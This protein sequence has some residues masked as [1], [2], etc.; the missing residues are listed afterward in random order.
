MWIMNSWICKLYIEF[1]FLTK[2]D[3]I[4]LQV[5]HLPGHEQHNCRCTQKRAGEAKKC[6]LPW[7][8][9]SLQFTLVLAFEQFW[10]FRLFCLRPRMT[11]EWAKNSNFSTSATHS[12][13]L[14]PWKWVKCAQMSKQKERKQICEIF[15]ARKF[16]NWCICHFLFSFAS[17][18]SSL[19]GQ[20]ASF[21]HGFL[22]FQMRPALSACYHWRLA[23]PIPPPGFFAPGP[24]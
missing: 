20:R 5:E 3:N 11:D 21:S 16:D 4:Y 15:D 10:V 6:H 17:L 24:D 22:L 2:V 18:S 23:R 7:P 19:L 9:N 14:L 8:T 13:Q 1:V 12:P